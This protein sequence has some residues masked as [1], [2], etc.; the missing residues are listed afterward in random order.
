M[1]DNGNTA[2]EATVHVCGLL[3]FVQVKLLKKHPRYSRWVHSAKK[4]VTRM[5][6]IQDSHR[7][8][9]RMEENRVSNRQKPS[10]G[11]PRR[12]SNRTPDQSS[13]RQEAGTSYG[14]PRATCG[15]KIP[16]WL[17]PLTEGLTR[18]SS[19]STDVSP[20]DV[21]IPHHPAK[22]ASNKSG[23]KHNS[24]THFPKAA[25]CGICRSTKVTRSGMQKK[26]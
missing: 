17:Q 16:E 9:S 18:G 14:R 20:A 1:T 13:G 10:L 4:T 15:N 23:G 6:G 8:P 19:S 22:L 21:A 2:E 3:I 12:A 25:N 5:N 24:F 26:S 7:N 11:G